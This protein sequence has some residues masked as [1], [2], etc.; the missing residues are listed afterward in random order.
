[1]EAASLRLQIGVACACVCVVR[2]GAF[3]HPAAA[4][5]SVETHLFV[6]SDTGPISNSTISVLYGLRISTSSPCQLSNRMLDSCLPGSARM[7]LDKEAEFVYSFSVIRGELL[8]RRFS[9]LIYDLN[10][11]LEVNP[12]V[13]IFEK[14][15]KLITSHLAAWMCRLQLGKQGPGSMCVSRSPRVALEPAKMALRNLKIIPVKPFIA[16]SITEA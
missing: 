2:R 11:H 12:S 7:Y 13:P 15:D 6:L 8:V 4:A 1:M 5:Q 10:F 16:V 14:E 9:S 3:S